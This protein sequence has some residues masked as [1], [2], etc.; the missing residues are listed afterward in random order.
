MDTNSR[1]HQFR[2]S[3]ICLQVCTVH[4]QSVVQHSSTVLFSTGIYLF[5]LLSDICCVAQFDTTDLRRRQRY[6]ERKEC[7]TID[8]QALAYNFG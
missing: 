2:E 3:I 8:F 1:I 5:F 7:I 6:R 4:K